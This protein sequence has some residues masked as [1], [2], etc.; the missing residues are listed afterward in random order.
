MDSLSAFFN[1][2]NKIGSELFNYYLPQ[3]ASNATI[4]TLKDSEE[5]IAKSE[6]GKK[7][8]KLL[9]DFVEHANIVRSVS[10]AIE[11]FNKYHS[12]KKINELLTLLNDI[13]VNPITVTKEDL[14]KFDCGYIPSLIE[15]YKEF[16]K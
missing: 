3:I 16:S 5:R 7:T 15:L 14:K 2:A 4:R 11:N 13:D 8:K 12:K 1:R 6:Y 10:K 9:W